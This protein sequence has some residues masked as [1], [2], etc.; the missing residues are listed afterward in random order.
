MVKIREKDQPKKR[1]KAKKKKFGGKPTL[2]VALLMLVLFII[3]L[4]YNP[5]KGIRK[6]ISRN[7]STPTSVS[8]EPQFTKH[9]ELT[10]LKDNGVILS[11]LDIE[12]AVDDGRRE[13][14]LMYRRQM[15]INRGMLFIFDDEKLR[16]FWMKNTYLP[17]DILYLNA[18]KVIVKIHE[19][20]AILNEQ[21][22]PSEFPARYVVEVNAGYCA[23]N[24][25]AVGD[26]MTFIRN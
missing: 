1:I 15:D 7:S 5:D 16:S 18:N 4:I 17:L 25:I 21:P 13:Q 19:N 22:I 23:L 2:F 26:R 8:S 12:L 20:V 3:A 9:G 14:G 10:F 11:K 6:V 24:R